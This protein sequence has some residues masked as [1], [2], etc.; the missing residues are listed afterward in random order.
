MSIGLLTQDDFN[1]DDS[2]LQSTP[3]STA[4][5]I[6]FLS[7]IFVT[8]LA[9]P[10]LGESVGIRRWVGVLIGFLGALVI[11]LPH[12]GS[13]V[14]PSVANDDLESTE[15]RLPA[16]GHLILIGAATSNALYPYHREIRVTTTAG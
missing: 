7:P 12:P 5:V 13:G 10:L 3:L 9:I 2:G 15:N 14:T 11:V 1:H 6:M 8:V 16:A 4:S